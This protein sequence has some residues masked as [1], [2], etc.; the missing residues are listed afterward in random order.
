MVV[1][2]NKG[3][4][5]GCR[6]A[7]RQKTCS[8]KRVIAGKKLELPILEVLTAQL[9]NDEVCRTL[10]QKYNELRKKRISQDSGGIDT[11]KQK[12]EEMDLSFRNI[13]RAIEQGA[14][15]DLLIQKLKDHE[16]QKST[17]AE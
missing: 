12:L 9:N 17:L 13:I 8:N 6:N 11:A 1:T 16:S 4:Y 15:S 5:Y 7:H 14:V 10:A 3:G 2:G